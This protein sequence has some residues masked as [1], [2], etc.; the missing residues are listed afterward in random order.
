MEDS[1]LSDVLKSYGIISENISPL[2]NGLI[3]YT[4]KVIAGKEE[5]VLQKI[6]QHVF[7]EPDKINENIMM[8]GDYLSGNQPDYLFPTPLKTT[9]G[10]GMVIKNGDY[11]RLIP[12]IQDSVTLQSAQSADQA[13]EAA[14][15]FSKF[16]FYLKDFPVERLN[17]TIPD[18]HN[19]NLRFIQFENAKK[20]GNP[21]RIKEASYLIDFLNDQKFVLD[22]YNKIATQHLLKKRV[23]HHDTK[24][25]NVLFDEQNKGICVIDL[26]TMMPGFFISDLGDMMRNYLSPANEEEIDL[27]KVHVRRDFY[28]AICE[29]YK[30]F[31]SKE[32]TE[33]ENAHFHY[34]GSFM[35]YM[36]ALRFLTDYMNND[37]Y[38]GITYPAQNL[39]RAKNQARLFVE[40]QNLA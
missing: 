6:N 15:Q 18:F 31:L 39:N 10:E 35:I 4:W 20:N 7:K 24:I 3:N 26:D 30:S 12:F 2:G 27:N 1:S 34:S 5:Y 19:L 37:I 29:G 21:R 11:Y 33:A 16:A 8:V 25:S 22:E 23:M 40:Y 17:I 38:Y 28:D 14:R 36:Q 13:Y 32:L 9:D